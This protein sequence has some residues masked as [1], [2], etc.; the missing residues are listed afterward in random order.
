MIAY[1]QAKSVLDLGQDWEH[2]RDVLIQKQ[3][4]VASQTNQVQM[5]DQ[6]ITENEGKLSVL[7]E[8]ESDSAI[9]DHYK[10]GAMRC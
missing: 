6:K 9:V 3:K 7:H 8:S 1:T 5:L 10:K 4:I 2:H